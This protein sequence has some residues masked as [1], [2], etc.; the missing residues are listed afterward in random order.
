MY[1]GARAKLHDLISLSNW[2]NGIH[3][4]CMVVLE[5]LT[6]CF[7]LSLVSFSMDLEVGKDTLY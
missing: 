7:T 5:I 1:I 3:I 4:N 6:P 2:N